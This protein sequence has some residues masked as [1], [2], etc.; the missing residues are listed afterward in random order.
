MVDRKTKEAFTDSLIKQDAGISQT[1]LK[2]QRMTIQQSL[3]SLDDKASSSQ[4]FTIRSIAAVVVCYV[5]GIAF[6]AA[7][8][9]LPG[10]GEI[11]AVIWT[12]CTWAAL[13]TAAVAIV[14]YWTIH[15]PKLE[16]GRIDLQVAMFQ[17]LQLQ[18][19][20]LRNRENT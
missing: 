12:V 16:K 1:S 9:W 5:F 20:E 18:I 17:E 13:I 15:R 2:E 4:R 19:A 11:L 10:H 6:N 7:Q 14:R 3:K 8:P